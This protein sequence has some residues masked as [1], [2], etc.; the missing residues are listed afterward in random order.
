MPKDSVG[1]STDKR[2][3]RICL[4]DAPTPLVVQGLIDNHKDNYVSRYERLQRYYEGYNDILARSKSDTS[5]PN[6]KIVS[7]YASYIVDMAQGFFLG[8]PVSYYSTNEDLMSSLQDIFNYNDEQDENSELSKMAGIKGRA[9]E[10]VYVDEE[11]KV[12]FNEVDADNIIVVYDTKIN[13]NMNFAI[14]CFELNNP[15][16]TNGKLMVE[17]YTKD[18]IY[19]YGQGD[20]GL[21]LIEEV[22]HYFGQVP[23]IEFMN[24]DEGIGDFER[25][26]SLI[27]AYDKSQ[28]DTANDFEEFTDAFLCLV[29]MNATEDDDIKELATNKILLL[30]EAGQAYWLIKE[31][32]DTALEN[33]K[34]R[35]KQDIH[36]FSKTPDMSDEQFASNASGIAMAYKTLALEQVMASKERKFK[37][38]LQK[39]NELICTI[40]NIQG[41]Q[42]D[43][44]DVDIKFTRNVPVN[45]KEQVETAT[46]LRGFTSDS[47]A[48]TELPMIDDVTLELGKI[49][50]EKTAYKD[51]G[52]VDLDIIEVGEE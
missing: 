14:R 7:G 38:G 28:S 8:K 22:P 45:V 51:D 15:L 42:F 3:K 31:I 26:I 35:L 13:P 1:G 29:N 39:R 48:L 33:Y 40:L 6:N 37:R 23:V 50:Q 10:I 46:M 20:M 5:K 41:N 43:Y 32:N 19:R 12:R 2:I 9:Y 16:D 27:D 47:T 21:S 17:V 36:K 49:E 44:R 18:T 34:N 11:A 25:V 52:G 4:D 24:N 30:D